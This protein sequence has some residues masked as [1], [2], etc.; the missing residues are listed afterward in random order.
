LQF[1]WI[2]YI[3]GINVD[4]FIEMKVAGTMDTLNT[5]HSLWGVIVGKLTP[6][7]RLYCWSVY[8]RASGYFP[9][10]D[11]SERGVTVRTKSGTPLEISRSDFQVLADKWAGYRDGKMKRSELTEFSRKTTYIL[12]IFHWAE[13]Q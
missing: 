10:L 8:G 1:I 12:S 9:I 2:G 4:T 6:R 3:L 5:F 13:L 7:P 11:V